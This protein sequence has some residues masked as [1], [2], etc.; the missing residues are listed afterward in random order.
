MMNDEKYVAEKFKA[1][2]MEKQAE[3]IKALIAAGYPCNEIAVAF[4]LRESYVRSYLN[5]DDKK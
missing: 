2:K 1:Y 5:R 4:N 3:M